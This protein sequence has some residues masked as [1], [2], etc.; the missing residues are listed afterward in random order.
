MNKRI[1]YFE[2]EPNVFVSVRTVKTD[3]G[4]M[5]IKYF[6]DSM[7]VTIVKANEPDVVIETFTSGSPHE[8]KKAIKAKLVGMGA[9]FS[10]ETR[11]RPPRPVVARAEG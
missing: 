10:A 9:V 8:M 5:I 2:K 3:H 4:D 1:R 11:E 7:L 6:G